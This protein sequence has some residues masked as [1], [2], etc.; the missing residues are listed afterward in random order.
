MFQEVRE[1]P[2]RVAREAAHKAKKRRIGWEGARR[3]ASL[4]GKLRFDLPLGGWGAKNTEQSIKPNHRGSG[5][6]L[7]VRCGAR[8]TINGLN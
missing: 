1:T 6:N 4:R 5:V 2:G 3:S 8:L 7:T